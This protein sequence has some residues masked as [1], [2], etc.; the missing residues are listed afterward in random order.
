M[1]AAADRLINISTPLPGSALDA[2]DAICVESRSTRAALVRAAVAFALASPDRSW[3]QAGY[4]RPGR[5]T[6]VD[7]RQMPLPVVIGVHLPVVDLALARG[8]DRTVRHVVAVEEPAVVPSAPVVSPSTKRSNSVDEIPVEIMDE[9]LDEIFGDHVLEED[10]DGTGDEVVDAPP[11]VP[12]PAYTGSILDV[13]TGV[14]LT[15]D[16]EV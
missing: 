6:T 1:P 10:T 3:T 9:I 4:R 13:L 16:G 11:A 7:P 5:P 15:E 8:E 14:G 12:D 2:L